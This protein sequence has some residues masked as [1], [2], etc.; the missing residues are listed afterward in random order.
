MTK[1]NANKQTR[2]SLMIQDL[3]RA[4]D[5]HGIAL[6]RVSEEN[7]GELH[8]LTVEYHQAHVETGGR[9]VLSLEEADRIMNTF[10][11]RGSIK[12]TPDNTRAFTFESPCVLN[13]MATL[14][15]MAFNAELNG[16]ELEEA[17]NHI[18]AEPGKGTVIRFALRKLHWPTRIPTSVASVTLTG[19]TMYLQ[20]R[21]CETYRLTV[22]HDKYT[23]WLLELEHEP[24]WG[25]YTAIGFSVYKREN[26]GSGSEALYTRLQEAQATAVRYLQQ[27][28]ALEVRIADLTTCQNCGSRRDGMWHICDACS[29]GDE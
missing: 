20:T 12:H 27:I 24:E 14:E 28:E 15:T 10:T 16:Y 17:P 13:L 4:A 11:L 19:N 1:S 9:A 5:R 21:S 2:D 25:K 3:R 22:D 18:Y 23:P 8:T 7:S 26:R 29:S 6:Q